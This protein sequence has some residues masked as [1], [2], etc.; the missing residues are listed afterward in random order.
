[1]ASRRRIRGF[2]L[3]ELLF[4]AGMV[5]I[6]IALLLPAVQQ[7][8]EAARRTQCKS[9]LANLMV[10]LS[11]YHHSHA[12]FPPGTINP[13]GPV[14]TQEE[15]IHTSW[16]VQLLP[17]L[18][19]NT[20]AVRHA[21]EL[22]VYADENQIVR[23]ARI[24]TLLCPTEVGLQQSLP[25]P[26][27]SSYAGVTGGKDVPLDSD[28]T[29]VFYLNSS[30]SLNHVRDGSSNQLA[31]G[32]RR[33]D[34]LPSGRELGW[35]SGTSATLRNGGVPINAVRSKDL[36]FPRTSLTADET[37]GGFSSGHTGGAQFGLADASVR[38]I[39]ENADTTVLRYL[40]DI[41]DGHDI[42]DF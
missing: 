15:G 40:C 31:V 36:P 28:N 1:M 8:R 29:G 13:S 6:L 19:Q 5:C 22:S 10:A 20:L 24:E 3:I 4:V 35:M 2:T 16:L 12:V 25:D 42:G 21:P 18:D 32:E 33:T 27:L 17:H 26:P 11:N 34:D 37:T 39:S 9:R 30:V 14:F 41:D 23:A 38:F 7:A